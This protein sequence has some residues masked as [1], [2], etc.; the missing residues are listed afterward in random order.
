MD[1]V[2]V[3]LFFGSEFSCFV[4]DIHLV[5]LFRLIAASPR[6]EAL[7]SLWVFVET[8]LAV[9]QANDSI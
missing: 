8:G 5:P 2:V 4:K 7:Q 6:T 1:A 9:Y 3:G